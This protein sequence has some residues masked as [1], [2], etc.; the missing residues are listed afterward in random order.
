MSCGVIGAPAWRFEMGRAQADVNGVAVGTAVAKLEAAHDTG[1]ESV[2]H[3]VNQPRRQLQDV[4]DL[5]P[6]HMLE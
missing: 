2:S 3:C 1:P 6:D 4:C 5:P